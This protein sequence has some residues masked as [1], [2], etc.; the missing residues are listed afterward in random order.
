M[1]LHYGG[2]CKIFFFILK[3]IEYYVDTNS[4]VDNRFCLFVKIGRLRHHNPVF[5]FDS[6]TDTYRTQEFVVKM[7][8]CKVQ[9]S[10]LFS[11][12]CMF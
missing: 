10:S 5:M 12:I 7:S 2:T 1:F 3:I 8:L 9:S 11:I 4:K 6:G